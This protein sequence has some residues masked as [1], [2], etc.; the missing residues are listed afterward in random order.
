MCSWG[1]ISTCTGAHGAMSW[2]TNNSSSS[3]AFRL[4]ISP[5]TILQKMQLG[6][7]CMVRLSAR[8]RRVRGQVQPAAND[9]IEEP[10]RDEPPRNPAR[11]EKEQP[12]RRRHE[13]ERA[14][15]EH[16]A[17]APAEVRFLPAALRFVALEEVD[18][19]GDQE[20]QDAGLRTR[21]HGAEGDDGVQEI[22][23]VADRL[24]R[25]L[26]RIDFDELIHVLPTSLD[27]ILRAANSSSPERPSRRSSSAST[28]TGASPCCASAIMV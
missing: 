12:E 5:A 6:S 7:R 14:D 2:K 8:H 13:I 20:Q 26:A 21:Q 17:D 24:Q 23:D 4:G 15:P 9:A 10:D 1:I 11:H 19:K 28:S 27:C 22:A 16:G 3:Y 25:L 18:G